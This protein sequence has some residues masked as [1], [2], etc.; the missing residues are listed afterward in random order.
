MVMLSFSRPL[1]MGILNLTPDSFSDGGRY[2]TTSAVNRAMEMVAEGA[3]IID[4][5]GESTRPQASRVSAAGQKRRVL[6]TIQILR[7]RL[8]E[9]F[10]ISID[11]TLSEVAR[12]AID[13]GASMINDVSA[14]REDPEMLGLAGSADI[15]LVLM[16]MQGTPETMQHAPVYRDVV[17][18]VKAFLAQRIEA[19]LRAGVKPEALLLDPGIGFGKQKR[20]NL[21]LLADLQQIGELGYPL[22]LGVSRKR[23][24]GA[25][26]NQT[27]PE[28]LIPAT[29]ACTALGVMAGVKVF[30]VHDV[31]Q[32]RQAL[33]VAW[34]IRNNDSFQ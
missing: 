2:E 11:T 19:A 15:P 32:N 20:H 27:Q 22:L 12:D 9:G 8:P 30:R 10:P 18:E 5:G 31:W 34:A 6:Q 25:I 1:I 26:S 14:G 23:F 3:D 17:S 16:H 29:C 4:I 7:E 24:M 13:A 28:Q 21:E 33:D